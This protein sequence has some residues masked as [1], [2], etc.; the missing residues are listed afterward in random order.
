MILSRTVS[1]PYIS[2]RQLSPLILLPARSTP[3]ISENL[4]SSKVSGFWHS[5]STVNVTAL[6][7]L[8]WSESDLNPLYAPIFAKNA[9]PKPI[10]AALNN[11][12]T[13]V[14]LKN[15]FR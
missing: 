1:F 6:K 14:I 12:D 5:G 13:A 11:P 8:N 4:S 7:S 2:K 9:I 3:L 15:D 10:T